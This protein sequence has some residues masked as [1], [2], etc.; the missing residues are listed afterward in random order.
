[1]SYILDALKKSERERTAAA[2]P[3]THHVLA[4]ESA[5]RRRRL[6][7]WLAI[8]VVVN[9]LVLSALWWHLQP[10]PP[11]P[12]A[13]REGLS[14]MPSTASASPTARAR[15]DAAS[16]PG[17]SDG[18]SPSS[19][20]AAALGT[21]A[22]AD[23]AGSGAAEALSKAAA[24]GLATAATP[25]PEDAPAKPNQQ[26]VKIASGP[27]PLLRDMPDEFRRAV[28]PV[29]LDVH[30][31]ADDPADRFV[32]VGLKRYHEGDRMQS[33]IR[34]EKI[35]PDGMVLSYQGTRFRVRASD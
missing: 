23:S 15:G 28:P 17:H 26:P 10:T 20:A 25:S 9:A 29:H 4:T 35:T 12:N 30:V 5:R 14:A 24:D 27:L 7:F 34:L 33:G 6:P 19:D 2:A 21:R 3:D 11:Q 22:P 32:L 13:T 31:Y 18:P 16:Q 1:M 8:I